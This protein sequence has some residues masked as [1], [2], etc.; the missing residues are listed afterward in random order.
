MEAE[1][2]G[3]Y[4]YK[5]PGYPGPELIDIKGEKVEFRILNRENIK[6]LINWRN[7]PE[8]AYW[9]TGGDPKFEFRSE[10]EANRDL[11]WHIENSSMLETYQFAIFTHDGNFIGT[12]DYREI[13]HVK[14]SCTV[15]ITIGDKN[16]WGKGYG[17]DA[18]SV[19]ADYLF[20][21]LNLRRI[22][23]DTWSGNERA[24]KS[25]KKCGFQVEGVLKENEF[26][27][28]KYFDTIIMGLLKSQWKG[29]TTD[30][31]H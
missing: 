20:N 13:D 27:N 26:V 9:A 29:S 15:G 31:H 18:L 8:V 14:R 30:Y 3:E 5:E 12:A 11:S 17:T 1:K 22:Q 2:I 7:D 16:Y 4:N 23:L 25:Y 28:G 6:T 19:L 21:R 10:E 24:I